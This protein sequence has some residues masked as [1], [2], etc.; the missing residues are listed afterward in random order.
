VTAESSTPDTDRTEAADSRP[1]PS[2]IHLVV[3]AV[4]L[5]AGT[6]VAAIAALQLVVRELLGASAFTTYGRLAPAARLL[7]DG[8]WLTI[9]LLGASYWALGKITDGVRRTPLAWGSLA[10]IGV[11]V[12]AGSIGI[13]AGLQTG[14]PGLQAPLWARA[15]M[16]VGFLLAAISIV[17]TARS[18]GDRLGA[19]GWY[20]AAAP[21][22]LTV[23]A[24][25]GLLPGL[26]GVP[27]IIH[28]GFVGAT[29]TGLFVVTAAVGLIYVVIGAITD[30]DLTETRPL[31]ALG[32]W[33]LTIVWANFSAIPL[34]FTPV[35]DWYETISIAFAIAAL[36]P[37]LT[38]AGDL[39]LMLRG[40]IGLI[41]D[42]V[43]L[44][45]V[46][47]SALSLAGATVVVLMWAWRA[48]SAV[49]Q[50]SSWVDASWAL[51]AL[52]GASFAIFGAASVMRGGSPARTVHGILSTIG[53][54][55][56]AVGTLAGGVAV[57]FSWAAGPASQEYANAGV[58]WKVTTDTI[59]P[60]AWVVA[61][62]AAVYFIAQIAFLASLGRRNTE[63]LEPP[64]DELPFDLEFEGTPRYATWSRL[65]WGVAGVWLFAALMTLVLPIVDDTDRDSTL[66]ADSSRTYASG[67]PHA[68]GRDLYVS[69]G[70]IACHTQVVRPVGTDVG[71]GPVS[72]AGDYANEQPAL[73]GAHRL[74]PD[75]MHYASRGEFFDPDLVRAHL[76]DPRRVAPWS[77]MPS[78]SYLSDDELTAL[79]SYLETLR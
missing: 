71:L 13:L 46:T 68:I 7:L 29:V 16:T 19:G 45:L 11:G 4:F 25:V 17:A 14:V 59:E 48:T 10:L 21:M 54:V 61:I 58:A 39:G 63:S 26:E 6:L 23:S 70:C 55:V 62:G 44:R 32:F 65:M 51:I 37:L 31:A 57:G 52:G 36:V 50:Y 74:G 3:A 41:S 56:I 35:P 33:S 24:L 2:Q 67:T 30:T 77:T 47:V 64:P 73:L 5:L 42:R 15:I 34:I 22:W 28:A 49:V 79:V 53:L 43:S 76:E 69:E 38:I 60:F 9:G 27:G 40:R 20:L 78:Y 66:L 18:S 12:L 8:G 1:N 75:L 72:I